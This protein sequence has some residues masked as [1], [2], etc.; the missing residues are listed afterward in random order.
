MNFDEIRLISHKS[1]GTKR[2]GYWIQFRDQS[3]SPFR[4]GKK[5]RSRIIKFVEQSFGPIGQRWQYQRLGDCEYILKLN[6]EVD[7][8]FLLLRFR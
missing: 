4:Y 1:V 8:L 6:S 2:F 7:F 3:N 5:A